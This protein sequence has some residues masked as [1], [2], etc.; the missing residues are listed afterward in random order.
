M[1]SETL[2][3]LKIIAAF[4]LV[5]GIIGM[6]YSAYLKGAGFEAGILLIVICN[7]PIILKAL[8]PE[9]PDPEE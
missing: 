6:A 5:I 1:K 4:C 8:A 2:F 9:K 3:M 7:T